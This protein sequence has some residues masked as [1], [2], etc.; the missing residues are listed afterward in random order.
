MKNAI[1]FGSLAVFTAVAV[2]DPWLCVAGFHRVCPFEVVCAE[3]IL[4]AA[5]RPSVFS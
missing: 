5:C 3:V 1:P 4:P 2:E